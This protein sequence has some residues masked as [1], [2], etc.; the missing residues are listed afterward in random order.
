MIL[1][2]DIIGENKM[3]LLLAAKNYIYLLGTESS[4]HPLNVW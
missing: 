3:N 4:Y 1:A 2:D